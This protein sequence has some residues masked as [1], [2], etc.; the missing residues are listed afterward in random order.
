MTTSAVPPTLNDYCNRLAL[1]DKSLTQVN[2]AGLNIGNQGAYALAKALETNTHLT[3]LSLSY[4]LISASGA[5]SLLQSQC[6]KHLQH[7]DLR[8][9]SIGNDGALTLAKALHS[10]DWQLSSLSI[11]NNHLGTTGAMALLTALHYNSTLQHLDLSTNHLGNDVAYAIRSLLYNNTTLESLYLWSVDLTEHGME[12]IADGLR[13]NTTLQILHLGGNKVGDVGAR[14]LA[15]AL[16]VNTSLHCLHLANAHIGTSGGLA[17]ANAMQH[18]ASLRLM[19]LLHNPCHCVDRLARVLQKS[20]KTLHEVRL[21]YDKDCTRN[22]AL[23]A[24]F[25]KFNQRG[26]RQI[27]QEVNLPW[28]LWNLILA[29][30]QDVDLVYHTLQAKPELVQR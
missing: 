22:R 16:H 6:L 19:D 30:Q 29:K 21:S 14:A 20:N 4:N 18:N 9:N 26:R 5:Q 25:L 15:Y 28:N 12:L 8:Y 23:I 17:L 10:G 11:R 27:E 13:H 1:N 3:S 24:L 7:L 2:L